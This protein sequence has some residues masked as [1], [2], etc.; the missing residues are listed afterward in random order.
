MNN[1]II[2][3]I[4]LVILILICLVF[5]KSDVYMSYDSD[6]AHGTGFLDD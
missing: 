2:A 1:I 6:S 5:R 3:T 4:V